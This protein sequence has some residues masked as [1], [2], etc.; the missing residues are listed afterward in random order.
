MQQREQEQQAQA[1]SSASRPRP[2]TTANAPFKLPR[3]F[4]MSTTSRTLVTPTRAPVRVFV[5]TIIITTVDATMVVHVV[6]SVVS[7]LAGH[8]MSNND[9]GDSKAIREF[10][11]LGNP[12][13]DSHSHSHASYITHK[14]NKQYTRNTHAP[15]FIHI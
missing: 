6:V 11:A 2:L 14:Q 12:V 10:F 7:W 5:V 8:N 13:T 1:L 3:P 15:S 9:D 4:S